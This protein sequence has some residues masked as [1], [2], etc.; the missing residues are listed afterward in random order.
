[1][2]TQCPKCGS[3]KI[4]RQ[5][6]TTWCSDCG[7]FWTNWQQAIIEELKQALHDTTLLVGGKNK[8]IEQQQAEIDRLRAVLKEA[9]IIIT[10]IDNC[11]FCYD[12]LELSKLI[13]DHR[14]AAEIARKGLNEKNT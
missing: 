12:C 5:S 3:D 8:T 9:E 4:V 10:H 6:A 1:M 14:C 2:T 11:E 7:V 13:E